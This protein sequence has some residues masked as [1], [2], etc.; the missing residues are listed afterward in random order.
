M[1]VETI[2]YQFEGDNMRHAIDWLS[3]T[4]DAVG[5]GVELQ[6]DDPEYL[7]SAVEH[8]AP[9]VA[10][11]VRKLDGDW[12]RT[13]GRKPYA[14]ALRH[15][16]G[17]TFYWSLHRPEILC[18]LS[19]KGCARLRD[20]GHED[21]V[22]YEVADRVTRLDI[23]TDMQ[24][25]TR[26]SDFIAAGHTGRVKSIGSFVSQ[27][28]ET[29]YL[30]SQKSDRYCRVYRY[31]DPHP[32]ADLLRVEMVMRRK[33]ARAAV[34]EVLLNGVESVAAGLGEVMAWK[35]T[36]WDTADVEASIPALPKQTR[37]TAGT[38]HWLVTQVAPA[39][40]RM[41]AEGEISEPKKWLTAH[42]LDADS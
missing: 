22:L 10:D 24:T 15:D 14:Y 13:A 5:E 25:D 28:G 18:E 30:G 32:R 26:P 4:I 21:S 8:A 11:F 33:M 19:G 40:K 6:S 9:F 41:V 20:E 1:G 31:D 7:A 23:A 35:H 36:D 39:F 17:V 16:A 3:F 2:F 42:F 27:T 37:E 12:K 38:L 29:V 34:T